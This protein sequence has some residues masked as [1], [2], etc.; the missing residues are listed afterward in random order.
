[1]CGGGRDGDGERWVF[2]F[3]RAA[4]G[5]RGE[6]RRKHTVLYPYRYP[7]EAL[8]GIEEYH[9]RQ[10]EGLTDWLAQPI[11]FQLHTILLLVFSGPLALLVGR[12][13]GALF[14]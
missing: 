3:W 6:A 14:L 11:V 5:A 2:L 13:D 12:E 9:G 1:M 4:Y 8:A 10:K 7:E